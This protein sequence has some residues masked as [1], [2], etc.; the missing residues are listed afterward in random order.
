MWSAPPDPQLCLRR[1]QSSP[2][3]NAFTPPVPDAPALEPR[4]RALELGLN[5]A[6]DTFRALYFEGGVASAYLWSPGDDRD[7]FA[8]VVLL[9]RGAFLSSYRGPLGEEGEG[10]GWKASRRR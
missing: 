7:R 2:W 6:V 4:L 1:T 9:K 3:S 8:G 5:E 10:V